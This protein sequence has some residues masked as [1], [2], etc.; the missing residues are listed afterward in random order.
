MLFSGEDRRGV[1]VIHRR[2][3]DHAGAICGVLSLCALAAFFSPGLLRWYDPAF[4]MVVLVALFGGSCIL[5]G[6][7]LWLFRLSRGLR[8]LRPAAEMAQELG[9]SPAELDT[10]CR[11]CGR[12]PEFVVEGEDHYSGQLDLPPLVLLRATPD[13]AAGTLLHTVAFEERGQEQLLR[14]SEE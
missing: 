6:A 14:S 9:M 4:R 13:E 5:A 7:S 11:E 1:P 10:N 12:L 2:P 8:G 3:P